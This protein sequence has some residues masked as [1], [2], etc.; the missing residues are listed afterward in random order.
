MNEYRLDVR[1]VATRV[2]EAGS[3]P[4][5]LLL[6]GGA[7][8]CSADDWRAAVEPFA[9]AGFRTLTFDQPGFGECDDPPEVS[10]AYRSKYA[11]GVLDALKISRAT[12][13]GHSQA[14]RLAVR[15]AERTPERVAAAIVLCTGSLLPPL[16]GATGGSAG[17][18]G[19]PSVAEIRTMLEEYVFHKALVTDELVAV[20]EC[21]SR[22]NLVHCAARRAAEAGIPGGPGWDALGE[23]TVPL[24]LVYGADDRGRVPERLA[25]ARDRYP[26]IPTHLLEACGHFAQWDQPA[27][28]VR[29]IADFA[30]RS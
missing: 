1:G 2:I 5:L 15:A 25:L 28:V 11:F 6:H 18:L 21:Y 7:L 30:G 22:G 8:G 14:G 20:Y 23:L 24:M 26:H 12:L 27:A 19:A 13:V 3:G 16:G 9:A 17:P 10:L 29:L 4:A